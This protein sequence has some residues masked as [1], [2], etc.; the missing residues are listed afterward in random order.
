MT[1]TCNS[2]RSGT[3]SSQK[4]GKV[5]TER[6]DILHTI[7]MGRDWPVSAVKLVDDLAGESPASA[8]YPVGTVV[9]SGDGAGDQT[10]GSPEVKVLV[11]R[12]RIW[13]APN[14]RASKAAGRSASEP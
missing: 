5:G 11:G 7:R 9:I 6:H 1:A 10:V 8:N 4:D 12:M 2:S 13:S 14:R 3:W